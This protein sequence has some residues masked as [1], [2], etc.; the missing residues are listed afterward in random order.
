MGP[1]GYNI[2]QSIPLSASPT[3]DWHTLLRTLHS[4]HGPLVLSF[5]ACGLQPAGLAYIAFTVLERLIWAC[6]VSVAGNSASVGTDIDL[7]GSGQYGEHYINCKLQVQCK[8][9]SSQCCV[10]Q[11][12]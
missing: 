1:Y 8:V 7:Q 3:N 6:A 12:F 10:V 5:V 11:R 2:L 4:D 9:Q